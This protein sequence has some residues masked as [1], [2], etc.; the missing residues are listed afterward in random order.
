MLV[1]E[2]ARK[3]AVLENAFEADILGQVLAAEGIAARIESYESLA[4]GG[5]F[6]AQRG[7]GAV[8]AEPAWHG[9]I[10]ELL[11]EIRAAKPLPEDAD[12]SQM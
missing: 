4:Y 8:F 5:L 3:A 10:R 1:Q 9:R 12:T 2:D 6:Q 7:W 11:Q